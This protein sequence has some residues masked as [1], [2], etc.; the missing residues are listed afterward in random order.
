MKKNCG[1]E[2]IDWALFGLPLPSG[3]PRF[4]GFEEFGFFVG[5]AVVPRVWHGSQSEPWGRA[6]ALAMACAKAEAH[7]VPSPPARAAAG[8]RPRRKFHNHEKYIPQLRN[9]APVFVG[10]KYY[11]LHKN[12]S[13]SMPPDPFTNAGE[14]A[15]G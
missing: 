9:G 8:W 15:Q 14:S 1:L 2:R 10:M 5:F 11:T 3:L 6:T 13:H 7:P 4:G 12:G